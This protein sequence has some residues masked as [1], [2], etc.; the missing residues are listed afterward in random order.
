V[1]DEDKFS[2]TIT[3]LS[4]TQELVLDTSLRQIQEIMDR[5]LTQKVTQC[6]GIIDGN[7]YQTD[8]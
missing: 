8:S 3:A 6:S 4:D 2:I 1:P 7:E 5:V